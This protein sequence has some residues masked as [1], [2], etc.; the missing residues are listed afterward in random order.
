M[1]II[2][3]LFLRGT[4]IHVHVHV[5]PLPVWGYISVRPSLPLSLSLSLSLSL[6]LSSCLS[7]SPPP[8]PFH[9]DTLPLPHLSL[10]PWSLSEIRI[11]SGM[12]LVYMCMHV[13]LCVCV[14]TCMYMY[15]HVLTFFI[16]ACTCTCTCACT[17]YVYMLMYMYVCTSLPLLSLFP[18]CPLQEVVEVE[19]WK[20]VLS[21]K[22][23]RTTPSTSATMVS[24]L[25][26][27]MYVVHTCTCMCVSCMYSCVPV[28][29][30]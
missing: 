11:L 2:L 19:A 13:L 25:L 8:T 6:C 16:H 27:C 26:M 17:L 24:L 9:G 12:R 29:A 28:H 21:W 4:C 20:L 23:C 1:C 15:M 7:Y 22:R 5:L 10:Y 3:S 30:S 14:Y 18:S